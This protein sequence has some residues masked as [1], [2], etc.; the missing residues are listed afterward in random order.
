MN[1]LRSIGA[2]AL[3]LAPALEAQEHAHTPGMTH[4]EDDSAF[5]AL[6]E[7]GRRSMGVDQ[8]K[9]VHVFDAL[10]DGGRIE[11]Q[12]DSDDPEA[13]AGIRQH[14]KEIETAFQNGDFSTPMAVHAG[15]VPGADIMGARK[16][17]IQYARTELPRGAELRLRSKD[18]AA[19]AAIH[20]FMAF[21]RTEHRAGGTGSP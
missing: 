9:A 13:I 12:A 1:R 18:P 20:D 3:L 16:E 7:Q 8:D 4:P 14:F 2:L 19:L 5:T 11:L 15:A 10:P 21:Q 6:K 17:Y